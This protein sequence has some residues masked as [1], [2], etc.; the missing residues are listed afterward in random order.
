MDNAKLMGAIREFLKK[1]KSKG[2]APYYEEA[3]S[4]RKE[5]RTYYQSFTKERLLA[6]T[7]EEF[8][9]YISKLW[10]MLIWGNKKYV[11]DKLIADNGFGA[12]KKQLAALLY[13]SGPVEKRWDGFLKSIKGMGPAMI[14][15]LLTYTNPDEYVIFNKTTI[16]CFGYLGIPDM[17]KYNYQYTGKKYAQV[18]AI[19][20]E[21]GER[22]KMAGEEDC[23]LLTV[24]YLLWDEILPLAEKKT[25]ET[26][27]APEVK[28]P[29]TANDSK[30]LHDEIKEKLVAIG[31][32][33]GFESRSEVRIATGAVVDAVWEAKIGNM[34][35]AIYVFE[36]Q[37]KGSIDSLILNLRKAQSNAAVQAVVAVADEEQL[38]RIVQES[39]GVID[40][41]SLRTWDSEDVLAVYDSLV[42]AHESINKLALVPESF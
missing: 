8:L 20:K 21:I 32:F 2:N 17:P 28:P 27:S 41:K 23:D 25:P 1:R 38:A 7:E 35:K 18:C 30:S 13:S 9:E 22:L 26:P 36:V 42:R 5:R 15:E 33:L 6:M 12:L 34:G 39:L 24:D 10:A 19:A 4:E 29:V 40:E 31:E 16:L 3:W 37:S 11:V 14:S